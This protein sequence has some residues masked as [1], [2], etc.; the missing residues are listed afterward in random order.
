M[1][2]NMTVQQ[3]LEVIQTFKIRK[4]SQIKS[5]TGNATQQ[6]LNNMKRN[7]IRNTITKIG[8]KQKPFKNQTKTTN[9]KQ[10]SSTQTKA[11]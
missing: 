5:I 2:Q 4:R 6:G 9:E 10:N 1:K 11:E 3:R 8:Q 7:G